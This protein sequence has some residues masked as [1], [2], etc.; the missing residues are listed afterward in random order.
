[1]AECKVCGNYIFS[2]SIGCLNCNN[3]NLGLEHRYQI[4]ENYLKSDCSNC[5]DKCSKKVKDECCKKYLKKGKCCKNC[6]ICITNV[7]Y[8]DDLFV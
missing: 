3:L 2:S 7:D 1:M 4:L 5:D 6:P 8:G